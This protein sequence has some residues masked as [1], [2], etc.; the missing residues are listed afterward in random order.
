MATYFRGEI[1]IESKPLEMD[2]Q[3][4]RETNDLHLFL[5]VLK[6]VC[7]FLCVC[8]YTCV[9]VGVYVCVCEGEP[10]LAMTTV[11]FVVSFQF[12]VIKEGI[13]AVGNASVRTDN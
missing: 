3:H 12:A 6:T 13:E 7:V 5:T 8:V 2:T 1:R 10:P 11:V 9:S 4:F